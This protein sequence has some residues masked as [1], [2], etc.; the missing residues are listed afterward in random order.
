MN[1]VCNFMTPFDK[2]IYAEE[3]SR[4]FTEANDILWDNKLNA[5]PIV[6]EKQRLDSF[7]IP[8]GLR[9]P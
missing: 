8:Q 7:R 1:K 4:P 3:R 9:Y 6:D 2:L 5:L